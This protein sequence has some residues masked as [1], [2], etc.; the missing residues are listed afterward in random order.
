MMDDSVPALTHVILE[1]GV[2]AE[3]LRH[4]RG[5]RFRGRGQGRDQVFHHPGGRGQGR[6]SGTKSKLVK[7]TVESALKR[8]LKNFCWHCFNLS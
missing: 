8:A 3:K 2:E 6:G 5:H 4:P 7:V 1:A